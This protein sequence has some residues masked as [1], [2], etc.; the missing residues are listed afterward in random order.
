MSIDAFQ[1]NAYKEVCVKQLF[2]DMQPWFFIINPSSGG[3]YARKHWHKLEATLKQQDVPFT[4]I[5]TAYRKHAIDIAKEAI[6][7]GHRQIVAVGGDGTINEVLQGLMANHQLLPELSLAVMP[8]GTGNDWAALHN[9]P[10]DN[11]SFIQTLQNPTFKQHDIGVASY[12]KGF[13]QKRYFLNFIGTGFDS[14]LLERMG[15]ASGKRYK[16]YL[17]L[18]SCLHRY[19]SPLF[20]VRNG[21]TSQSR[22]LMLMSC[23]GKFGGAGMKFAPDAEYDDGLFDVINIQDMPFLQRLMSLPCLING[24]VKQHKKVIH[25]QSSTLEIDCNETFKFQCDGELIAKLPV[26]IHIQTKALRVLSNC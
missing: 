20:T 24:K 7:A 23:I 8:W 18:L 13:Q 17:T 3:G 1:T 2:I 11:H 6:Q 21:G 9:I 14:F 4:H 19:Q 25:F 26:Q 10:K 16:Y 22:S 5:F 15:A 12:G